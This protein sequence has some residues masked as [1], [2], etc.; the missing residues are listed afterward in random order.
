VVDGDHVGDGE[1]RRARDLLEIGTVIDDPQAVLAP[2]LVVLAKRYERGYLRGEVTE[3]G[4]AREVHG[5][6]L[7]RHHDVDD[8]GPPLD[9]SDEHTRTGGRLCEANGSIAETYEWGH[10]GHSLRLP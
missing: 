1:P 7:T 2:G 10:R 9:R 3:H 6:I 5:D 4:L 8:I